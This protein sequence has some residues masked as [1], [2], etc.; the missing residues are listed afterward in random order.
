MKKKL[1]FFLLVFILFFGVY[2]AVPKPPLTKTANT[3]LSITSLPISAQQARD[4][5]YNY[6]QNPVN[7]IS[8]QSDTGLIKIKS[9]ELD[10]KIIDTIRAH[11]EITGLRCYFGKRS[12]DPSKKDY[13]VLIVPF[14]STFGNIY[15]G[16]SL[17][18]VFDW[19]RPGPVS[20]NSFADTLGGQ[21]R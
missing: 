4:W 5:I 1:P 12:T 21:I 16:D 8:Y 3:Q 13:T 20:S 17:K 11:S 7:Q 2:T 15:S 6:A 9:W 14:N 19:H 18:W 10:N